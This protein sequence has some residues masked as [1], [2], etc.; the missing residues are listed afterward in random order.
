MGNGL[1]G[2]KQGRDRAGEKMY[3]PIIPKQLLAFRELP[4]QEWNK[5]Q[6]TRAHKQSS[7]AAVPS[8]RVTVQGGMHVWVWR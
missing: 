2:G 8:S 3:F 6:N 1:S 7:T 4:A 5:G